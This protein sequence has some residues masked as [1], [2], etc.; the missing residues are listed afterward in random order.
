MRSDLGAIEHDS[1]SVKDPTLV[2]VEDLSRGM[3]PTAFVL[4]Q[5]YP[6]PFNPETKI[7]FSITRSSLVNLKIFDVLGREVAV[8]LNEKMPAGRYSVKWDASRFSSGIYF[9]RLQAGK[10]RETK[11]MILLK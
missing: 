1:G 8:L 3:L 10:F 7:E 5:N 6:N 11:R 2:G 4:D 9:Y